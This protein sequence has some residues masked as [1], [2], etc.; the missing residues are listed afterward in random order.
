MSNQFSPGDLVVTTVAQY[1]GLGGYVATV[2]IPP[3]KEGTP[4]YQVMFEIDGV[5]ELAWIHEDEL[6]PAVFEDEEEEVEVPAF[7]MSAEELAGHTQYL[8]TK[9]MTRI[10]EVG[11][12]EAFFGFQ[13]FEGKDAREILVTLLNK[14]EEGLALYAQAHILVSRT[15][16]GLQLLED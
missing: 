14:I 13:E 4:Q 3:E 8:L 2:L 9:A 6:E 10:T 16:I 11:A 12:Q 15:I 5:A 7:G 1:E